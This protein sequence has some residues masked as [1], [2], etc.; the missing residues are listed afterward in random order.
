MKSNPLEHLHEDQHF[1]IRQM[2]QA[3]LIR[4]YFGVEEGIEVSNEMMF[5][6]IKPNAALFEKVFADV[7]QSHPSFFE[8]AERDFAG[9]LELVKQEFIAQEE[10]RG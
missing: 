5:G 9:A 2:V 6:W 10:R 3:A 1:K 4:D 7:T 8:D